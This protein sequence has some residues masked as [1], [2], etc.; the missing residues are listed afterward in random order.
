MVWQ[1]TRL[2]MIRAA[3]AVCYWRSTEAADGE[4]LP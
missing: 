1:A 2:R 4:L 3:K